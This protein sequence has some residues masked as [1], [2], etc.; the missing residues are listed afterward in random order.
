MHRFNWP[1]CDSTCLKHYIVFPNHLSSHI[2][3]TARCLINTHFVFCSTTPWKVCWREERN[4]MI[5]WQSQSTWE[6]SPKPSTRLW[7]LTIGLI[8]VGPWGCWAV[9]V[10][11]PDCVHVC[12]CW[13]CRHGNRTHAVKSC[14]DAASSLWT[15]PSLPFCF[16][17]ISHHAPVT[18]SQYKGQDWR[19]LIRNGM[20]GWEIEMVEGIDLS[21]LWLMGVGWGK[22]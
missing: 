8:N 6:T 15:Y 9:T 5:L 12:S 2:L 19:R 17:Y 7:V 16:A 14:D 11:M 10:Q 22:K 18:S 4:W 3:Y 1:N 13:P 20:P 21:G